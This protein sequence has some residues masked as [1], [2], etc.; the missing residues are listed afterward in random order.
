MVWRKA[1]VLLPTLKLIIFHNTCLHIQKKSGLFLLYHF[2][3]ANY[4][5]LLKNIYFYLNVVDCPWNKWVP[6]IT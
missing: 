2:S 1:D 5:D 4:F 6:V 3:N